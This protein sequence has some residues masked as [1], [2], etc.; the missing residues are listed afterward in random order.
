M[1]RVVLVLAVL[2]IAGCVGTL[3]PVGGTGGGDDTGGTAVA[4]QMF[5]DDVSPLLGAACSS[6]HAG[7]TPIGPAF[8]GTG[9]VTEYYASITAST[10]VGNYDP[11]VALLLTKGLHNNGTARAWT[12]AE[13]DAIE[14]WL[15]AEADVRGL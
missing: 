2:G 8:L 12:T 15:L 6:C 14:T 4:R 7:T 5:D 1:R 10:V 13:A 3:E 9:A 11:A